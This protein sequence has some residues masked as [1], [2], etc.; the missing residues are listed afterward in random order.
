MIGKT[1][2]HYKILNAIGAG[3]MGK[4]FLAEDIELHRKVVLKFLHY[5]YSS[6]KD[7]KTRFKLEARAAAKLDH[8]NIVT[9]YDVGE[10]EGQPYIAMQFVQGRS[11]DKII[12]N[13]ELDL[14]FAIDLIIQICQGLAN[15]HQNGIIHRDIK[16]ANIVVDKDNRVKILDFGLAKAAGGSLQTQA[17][18]IMGTADYMSPEQLR[19]I[20]VDIRSDIFSV[21]VVIYEMLTGISPFSSDYIATTIYSILNEEPKSLATY[22][23]G[24]PAELQPIIDKSLAKSPEYRYKDCEEVIKDLQ[25]LQTG[26]SSTNVP[27]SSKL[28]EEESPRKMAVLYLKNLGIDDDEFLSYGITED[29]IIDLTRIGSLNVEP[30]RTVLFYKNSDEEIDVIA[31][32]L[33]V[34]LILDGSIHKS[35]SSIRVS[36]QLIDV[37]N[38][39][40]LWADRWDESPDNLPKVKQ[41]LANG[42]IGALSTG[43]M[44]ITRVDVGDR[45]TGDPLAYEYYLRGKYAF[46]HKKDTSDIE[47]A[48]GLYKHA[49][50]LEPA[51]LNARTGITEILI[52]KGEYGEAIR[53]L[54]SALDEARKR[55]ALAEE[56]EIYRLLAEAYQKQSKWNE[57]GDHCHKALT[58]SRQ[59][60]DLAGEEQI[61]GLLISIDQWRAKF[62]RALENYERLIELNRRVGDEDKVAEALKNMG[63]VYFRKGELAKARELYEKSLGIARRIENIH[64]EAKCIA[65]IGLIHSHAMRLDEALNCYESALQIYTKIG[66]K[67]GQAIC[68]NNIALVYSSKGLFRKGIKYYEK[69]ST[70]QKTLGNKGDF[71]LAQSNMARLMAV[72][73]DAQKAIQILKEAL[74]IAIDLNYPFVINVAYDSL[75][76]SYFC[77]YDYKQ[78]I[79]EYQNALEVAVEASLGRETALAR[80]NLGQVY[81]HLGDYNNSR[82]EMEKATELAEEIG[83]EYVQLKTSAYLSALKARGDFFDIGVKDLREIQSKTERFGDPRYIIDFKIILGQLLIELGPSK[84]VKDEGV[85]ILEKALKIAREYEVAYQIAW[86]DRL[87]FDKP[88]DF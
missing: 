21:G 64:L 49:L 20:E 10:Y 54:N 79:A 57:A 29:L 48:I 83:D 18:S 88:T 78:S 23:P 3:G 86:I 43:K 31:R 62:D 37:R 16:P 70:I 1:I 74:E 80:C 8:P 75:G 4:I 60:N 17:G 84:S 6:G 24:L 46:S 44:K 11:L 40:I 38:K 77:S 53:E 42:V 32:K 35:E 72:I 66:D 26:Q 12:K 76:Y 55:N 13:R 9:I 63:N 15:A 67:T 25:K 52:H 33:K 2:S 81:Y 47:V 30:M 51:D 5:H 73:G 69:A 50:E 61:L 41:D 36:A 59:L 56:Q 65:N 34:D 19:G 39:K 28:L 45:E 87:L 14:S 58:I 71:A 82:E 7:F 68:F 22:N 27:S 85:L